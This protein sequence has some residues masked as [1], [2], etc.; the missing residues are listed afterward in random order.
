MTGFFEDED[1]YTGPPLDVAMV[2]RAE[3]H[4]RVRLPAAY[5]DLLYRQNGGVPRSRCFPTGFPTTWAPDH[6]QISAIRGVGGE[7]GIDS[8]TG[9]GN[10]AM[11]AEWGYPEIGVVIC[12]TPSAGHDTIMLDY[13][14]SGPS[15]EP[16]VAY[17][18]EDRVP[19]RI[20]E[21]FDEFLSNLTSCER[22]E[23]RGSAT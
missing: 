6:I 7:W 1:Y 9:L 12:D 13:T 5:L 20:A 8:A 22:F 11:I 16:A 3:E 14:E 15:G 2:R 10:A 21:S 18:D 4:L 17:I 23:E 19:R